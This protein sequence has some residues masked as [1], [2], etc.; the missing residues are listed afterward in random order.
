MLELYPIPSIK[1][2]LI[3]PNE[4]KILENISGNSI[5][6]LLTAE[7][8]DASMFELRVLNQIKMRSLPE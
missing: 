8:K 1:N 7:V 6:I 3:S 5:E 4:E 2:I